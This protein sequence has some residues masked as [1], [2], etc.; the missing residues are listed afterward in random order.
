MKMHRIVDIELKSELTIAPALKLD[1]IIE[2]QLNPDGSLKNNFESVHKIN[3]KT[4]NF[5]C[6]C[7]IQLPGL[8]ALI[9]HYD[10]VHETS[11]EYSCDW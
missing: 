7:G 5:S 10:A 1:N 4:Y 2:S 3:W 9:E 11:I 8:E 6:Q